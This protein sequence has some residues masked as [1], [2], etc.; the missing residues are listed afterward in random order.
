M[1]RPIKKR[2][3]VLLVSVV[4]IDKKH[5]YPTAKFVSDTCDPNEILVKLREIPI[6]ENSEMREFLESLKKPYANIAVWVADF[7]GN[8]FN[9]VGRSKSE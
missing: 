9:S 8:S 6:A 1:I 7:E 5:G 3:V 4:D 2:E